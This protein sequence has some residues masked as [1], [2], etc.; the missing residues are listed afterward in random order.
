MA[1]RPG[2]WNGLAFRPPVKRLNQH[3]GQPP[4]C[5][6][7][8]PQALRADTPCDCV[9]LSGL[10]QLYFSNPGPHGPGIECVGPAGPE[11]SD[12]DLLRSQQKVD[13][14]L[15]TGISILTDDVPDNNCTLV[16]LTGPAEIPLAAGN[17]AFGGFLW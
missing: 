16:R 12:T 5:E 17:Q 7:E 11:P 14:P 8:E 2:F 9:G 1:E 10:R 15:H 4:V 3:A 13:P 6:D